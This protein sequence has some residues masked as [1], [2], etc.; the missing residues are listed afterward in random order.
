MV[1]NP[2]VKFYENIVVTKPWGEEIIFSPSDA[3]YTFKVLKL[4]NGGRLS[5]QYHDKKRE[6][7]V[8]ING[9]ANLIIGPDIDHLE[10]IEMKMFQGYTIDVNVVHRMVGVPDADIM[11]GSTPETGN[12]VRLQDDYKRNTETEEMRKQKNRGWN[13]NNSL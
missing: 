1:S 11:E 3:D 12:T 13:P 6:T 5:L 4:K 9:K 7:L 2:K 8:L 10:T